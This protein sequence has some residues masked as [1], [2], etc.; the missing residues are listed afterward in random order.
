MVTDASGNVVHLV[1]FFPKG[2]VLS[3]FFGLKDSTLIQWHAT[4][5][6]D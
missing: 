1:Y 5:P 4:K 3:P 6:A 2:K